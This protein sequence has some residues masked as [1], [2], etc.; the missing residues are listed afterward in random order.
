MWIISRI[1]IVHTNSISNNLC[2]EITRFCK[3]ILYGMM[4]QKLVNLME[5]PSAFILL[6]FLVY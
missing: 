3:K 2:D 4:I 5:Y 1:L 6:N